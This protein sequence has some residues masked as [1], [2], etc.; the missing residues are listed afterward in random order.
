MGYASD[1]TLHAIT[2]HRGS[3]RRR[4]AWLPSNLAGWRYRLEPT[5]ISGSGP[6]APNTGPAAST[7][8]RHRVLECASWWS[9]RRW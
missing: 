7:Y 4:R 8:F 3:T 9:I 6:V 1:V 5:H 2:R